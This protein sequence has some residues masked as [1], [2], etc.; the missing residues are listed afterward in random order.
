MPGRRS[1]SFWFSWKHGCFFSLT[2][3]FSF[4]WFSTQTGWNLKSTHSTRLRR[5][6]FNGCSRRSV[7]LFTLKTFLFKGN[8]SLWLCAVPTTKK[9]LV[10]FILTMIFSSSDSYWVSLQWIHRSHSLF[11]WFFSFWTFQWY[12]GVRLLF[13]SI[14]QVCSS[15]FKLFCLT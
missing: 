13:Q 7:I 11:Y 2:R 14:F 4:G 12:G 9:I 3:S 5:Q 6:K 10:F 15:N 8:Y 1:F